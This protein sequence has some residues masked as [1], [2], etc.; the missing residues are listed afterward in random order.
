MKID[1]QQRY[2]F[3]DSFFSLEGSVVM[4]LSADAAVEVCER[5]SQHGLFI[6]RVEGGVWHFP[7]FEARLDC[8]WDSVAF[9]IGDRAAEKNNLAAADFIRSERQLHDAFIVTTS[10]VAL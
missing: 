10:Q 8:I 1:P 3:S 7:G 4:K 5:A 6:A 9:P 2:E